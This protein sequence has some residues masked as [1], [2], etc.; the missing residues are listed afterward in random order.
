MD[1]VEIS[2]ASLARLEKLASDCFVIKG[3]PPMPLN[4]VLEYL[5]DRAW[6]VAYPPQYSTPGFDRQ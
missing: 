1:S 3:N 6:D 4:K 5:I 2:P